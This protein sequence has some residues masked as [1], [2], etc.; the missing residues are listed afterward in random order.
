MRRGNTDWAA[1][2]AARED[3][4]F[5]EFAELSGFPIDTETIESRPSPK[6]DIRCVVAGE[7]P[8]AFE[9]VEIC[10]HQ[11]AKDIGDQI[12]RGTAAKFLM[13]DDPGPAALR[14]KLRKSYQTDAPIELVCY[15]GRTAVPNDLSLQGL[16]DVT[17]D[18][19]IAP[20]RR[21]CFLGDTSCEVVAG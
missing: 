7:G 17:D 10:N 4:I 11:L 15:T 21:V 19:G 9:M 18:V 8:V 14:S 3:R 12:K 13:L 6:P 2:K 5:R 16:R 1:E 20:F